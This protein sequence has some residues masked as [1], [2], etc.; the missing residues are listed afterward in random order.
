MGRH[1]EGGRRGAEAIYTL[2]CVGDTLFASF[3]FREAKAGL[4][5]LRP[6]AR[7]ACSARSNRCAWSCRAL[8][9]R[10]PL[11][12]QAID[13]P[14]GV[15]TRTPTLT[16]TNSHTLSLLLYTKYCTACVGSLL[17]HATTSGDACV[18]AKTHTL[19]ISSQ[20]QLKVAVNEPRYTNVACATVSSLLLRALLL[21]LTD[22]THTWWSPVCSDARSA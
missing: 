1:A 12:Q 14:S 19:G 3:V 8:R 16:V 22:V 2:E 20:P 4:S 6:D 9:I 11:L 18:L 21:S 10:T 7:S 17:V 15:T 13:H 5:Q